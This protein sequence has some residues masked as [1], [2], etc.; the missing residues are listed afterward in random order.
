MKRPSEAIKVTPETKTDGAAAGAGSAGQEFSSD[1]G[2]LKRVHVGTAPDDGSQTLSSPA[3]EKPKAK[4]PWEKEHLRLIDLRAEIGGKGLEEKETE[5]KIQEFITG[6]RSS[7]SESYFFE[8]LT[9][10]Y[11]YEYENYDPLESLL[12]FL[13][14]EAVSEESRWAIN[15]LRDILPRIIAA[16]VEPQKLKE[17]LV[18]SPLEHDFDF[19][20]SVIYLVVKGATS[21]V[22]S[23]ELNWMVN[24][25][26]TIYRIFS[27]LPDKKLLLSLF[28]DIDSERDPESVAPFPLI[29][30]SSYHGQAWATLLVEDFLAIL[31]TQ[32]S[33]DFLNTR[34]NYR[35]Q[36]WG[37]NQTFLCMATTMPVAS[38]K[39]ATS[40]C[41]MLARCHSSLDELLIL[42]NSEAVNENE[43]DDSKE[44]D[45][46]GMTSIWGIVHLIVKMLPSTAAVSRLVTVFEQMLGYSDI[47]VEQLMTVLNSHPKNKSHPWSNVTVFM[48]L[49]SIVAHFPLMAVLLERIIKFICTQQNG[50]IYVWRLFAP[51]GTVSPPPQKYT[52]L[53]LLERFIEVSKREALMIEIGFALLKMLSED[54]IDSLLATNGYRAAF[55]IMR[56]SDQLSGKIFADFR[57]FSMWDTLFVGR[58][59]NK[60]KK[61]VPEVDQIQL[62]CFETKLR[63]LEFFAPKPSVADS[64]L[65]V[66]EKE[67]E[68]RDMAE[69][70]EDLGFLL[71]CE[72][73]DIFLSRYLERK[74]SQYAGFILEY[75]QK[76]NTMRREKDYVSAKTENLDAFLIRYNAG[77][78]EKDKELK[79]G[80]F[81]KDLCELYCSPMLTQERR[82]LIE[83]LHRAIL[84]MIYPEFTLGMLR[85]NSNILRGLSS[86]REYI[87]LG[88]VKD[89]NELRRCSYFQELERL[90][91]S[92]SKSE[93]QADQT[94][95]LSSSSRA[96][97]L[98]PGTALGTESALA[99]SSSSSSSS[100]LTS[101]I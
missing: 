46:D 16:P 61:Q 64:T 32:V 8:I 52:Q 90:L 55:T 74:E 93:R 34:V 89:V 23:P 71:K 18:V 28:T 21:A 83:L 42:L 53:S 43:A 49:V 81:F 41:A 26:N 33:F 20:H 30:E 35:K 14:V 80:K 84:S 5:I 68:S 91:K 76:V 36:A 73:T 50:A 12:W 86:I 59:W 100:I 31:E 27:S 72:G 79:F 85:E 1:Q 58:R 25:V 9:A 3:E 7:L 101:H 82:K 97:G 45:L 51:S 6:I 60:F 69:I 63:V 67:S 37:I 96:V 47:S 62:K 4:S 75:S 15:L 88:F 48:M 78:E 29:I 99:S 66:D 92:L 11:D 13:T 65:D 2:P 57:D 10:S 87:L 70:L 19:D 98:F 44:D 39:M 40:M 95:P 56:V 24:S 94:L 22:T 17:A 38:E 77:R 54:Q